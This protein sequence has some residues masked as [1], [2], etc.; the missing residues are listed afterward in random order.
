MTVILDG[1]MASDRRLAALK[2]KIRAAGLTPR[3][4]TVIVGSDPAS[5]MYVRMKHRACGQVGI[6]SVSVEIQEAATTE[7]VVERVSTLNRDPDIDGILVQLPLP[8]QIDTEEVIAAVNVE[9]DVDGFHPC[10]LGHLFSGRPR[11]V[12]CTPQGIMTLFGEYRIP[13]AGCHAVVAGRSIDVGRPMAA[14]L[15]N[16]DATVTVCHSRTR[17]LAGELMRADIL[18]SAVGKARF[19]TPEMVKPGAAVIDVGINYVDGKLCGD[20]DFDAVKDIAGAITPVPGGVGPMTIAALMENTWK[21]AVER[22][23]GPVS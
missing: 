14:L 10:N 17:D 13:V 22:P 7:E 4:A 11:F 19:I 5:R 15:L 20:V 8:G 16:A 18:V 2:E 9:K 23:C 12:P 3:L 6:V 21:S 1:K